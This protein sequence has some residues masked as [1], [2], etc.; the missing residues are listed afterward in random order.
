[1]HCR[2][3]R[4]YHVL[5]VI[6][7]FLAF[8]A[9]AAGV[10]CHRMQDPVAQTICAHPKMLA[11]DAELSSAYAHALAR[12]PS[13]AA[14]LRRDERNWVGERNREI[15]WSLA[16]QRD[17]PSLP[18]DPE[19]TLAHLYQLRIAFL[20]NIDDPRATRGMPIAQRLLESAAAAP[21]AATDTLKMLQAAGAVILPKEHGAPD[22]ERVIASLAAPPDADLRAALDRYRP[23]EFTVVYL[24]SAGLGGAFNVEGTAD[25]QYWVMFKKRGD[26]TVPLGASGGGPIGG[27]M[28][29]GGTT[30][31]LALVNGTPV[32][33]NVT[34]DPL[35]ASVTDVEWQR[36]LG[37]DRWGPAE[38]IRFRYGYSLEPGR[39]VA[40]QNARPQCGLTASIAMTAARS[41]LNAPW[42]LSAQTHPTAAEQSQFEGMLSYAPGRK[43][44]GYCAYPAWFPV[45]LNGKLLVGGASNE[46]IG[47]HPDGLVAVGFW[48][49]DN[50][51]KSWWFVDHEIY[52]RRDR[53][54]FAARIADTAQP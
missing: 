26:R 13:R 20:R 25:C 4:R 40:R 24:P 5:V 46:H 34:I 28:R 11:L 42:A 29:D 30:G 35:F 37:A 8:P 18:A 36:W 6:T 22:P 50:G 45:H 15:W 9:L 17:F 16:S 39:C 38:R 47:C 51:G 43:D 19:T 3:S 31:Y 2:K 27:C 1:M 12:D 23:H 21:I 48:G 53:L 44:W 54:L 41:Y 32:A 14:D 10:D 7:T 49:T 33:L 52:G